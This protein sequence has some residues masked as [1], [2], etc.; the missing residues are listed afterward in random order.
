MELRE[1]LEKRAGLIHEARAMLDAAEE[2]DRGLN[3]EEEQR[4]NAL[5]DDANDI[6]ERVQRA[7]QMDALQSDLQ[8][9]LDRKSVV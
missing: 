4:Y 1:L 8:A 2:E 5:L 3:A 9:P 6:G 7:Q